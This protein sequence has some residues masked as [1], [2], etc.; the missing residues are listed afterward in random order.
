MEQLTSRQRSGLR[1]LANDIPAIFQIGKGGVSETTIRELDKALNARELIKITVLKTAEKDAYA[2]ADE[3]CAALDAQPVQTIGAR[4][5]LYR[6]S[7]DHP[8]IDLKKL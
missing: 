4:I 8:A 7:K 3:L 5:V 1:A 6:P 2:V